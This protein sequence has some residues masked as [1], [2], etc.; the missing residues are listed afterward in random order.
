MAGKLDVLLHGNATNN[1]AKAQ[2]IDM[3]AYGERAQRHVAR[4]ADNIVRLIDSLKEATRGD[5]ADLFDDCDQI[6]RW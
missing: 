2:E 6:W 4:L 5:L 3:F 1:A